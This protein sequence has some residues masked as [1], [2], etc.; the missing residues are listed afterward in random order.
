[1]GK[2]AALQAGLCCMVRLKWASV[3]MKVVAF[4]ESF[5]NIP[6]SPYIRGLHVQNFHPQCHRNSCMSDGFVIM[7]AWLQR[8]KY[9]FWPPPKEKISMSKGHCHFCMSFSLYHCLQDYKGNLSKVGFSQMEKFL[10]PIS[11]HFFSLMN[12]YL[13]AYIAESNITLP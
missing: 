1:M 11:G 4:T 12:F 8:R 6:S 7:Y 5:F 3:L 13:W 10:S 2:W 9:K